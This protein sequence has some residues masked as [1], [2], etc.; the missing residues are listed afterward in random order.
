MK[1]IDIHAH[2]CFPNTYEDVD[3]VVKTIQKEMTA[4]IASSARYE[5]GLDV[6][7]LAEK[8]PGV[9]FVSLGYHPFEGNNPEK[10]KK[11]ILENKDRIVSVGE[12]GLDYHWEQN[13][14][15]REKQKVLFREFLELA[16]KINKPVV[17][18][19]W[20]AERE[21]FEIAREYEIPLIFHC[22]T[23]SVELAKE[24][25]DAGFYVSI[26]T[27]ICFSKK[28]KKVAKVVPMEFMLLETDAPFLDPDR[29][30]KKNV[31]WNIKLSAEKIAEVK[32]MTAEEVLEQTTKNAIKVFGLN[33]G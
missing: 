33:I 6:L 31:P 20:D 28:L 29:D 16:K 8:Y 21:C 14:E 19:S 5:E 30:R 4:V 10:T 26:S 3:D 9:V 12:V 27:N 25:V 1:G 11:L 23:G 24:I 2:L 15:K 32:E 22:F 13:S 17:I 18:H 7:R